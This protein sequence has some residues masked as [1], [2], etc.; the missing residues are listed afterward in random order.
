MSDTGS[1]FDHDSRNSDPDGPYGNGYNPYI[2]VGPGSSGYGLPAESGR[3]GPGRHVWIWILVVVLII[4]GG[5]AGGTYWLAGSGRLAWV[6]GL[7]GDHLDDVWLDS[8]D[9]R[10]DRVVAAGNNSAGY[11][12]SPA[13]LVSADGG[14]TWEHATVDYE[15]SASLQ[16]LHVLTTAKGWAL[17][18]QK[19]EGTPVIWRSR[20]GRMWQQAPSKEA[21][22]TTF[23]QDHIV[24]HVLRTKN[25]YALVGVN[26]KR[27]DSVPVVWTMADNH[28][29]QRHGGHDLLPGPGTPNIRDVAAYGNVLVMSGWTDP[30]NGTGNQA[31]WRSTDGG[32]SWETADPPSDEVME[33]PS[34][35]LATCAKGIVIVGRHGTSNVAAL[36]TDGDTW[37]SLGNLPRLS[38]DGGR[39]STMP[40]SVS[41]SDAGLAVLMRT[42]DKQLTFNYSADGQSWDSGGE[43]A[44]FTLPDDSPSIREMTVTRDTIVGVV[45]GDPGSDEGAQ[46]YVAPKGEKPEP[47]DLPSSKE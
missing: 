28:T 20:H 44:T 25:G 9:A 17:V 1:P 36:S 26:Y 11:G 19:S 30:P 34:E 21:E 40:L 15:G 32:K 46:I 45:N 4:V 37:T 12:N 47:A 42:V 23:T 8:I 3:Q 18:G 29:W 7:G 14:A 41:A 35:Q 27:K 6:P 2:H 5:V 39:V 13:V 43:D 24:D 16:S 10:G 33:Y 38:S 22:L 31:Y